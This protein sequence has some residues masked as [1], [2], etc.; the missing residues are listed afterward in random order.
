MILNR[1]RT[2]FTILWCVVC[3]FCACGIGAAG[4]TGPRLAVSEEVW[5]FGTIQEGDTVTHVFKLE[6]TGTSELVIRN[7]RT[8]CGCT[9]AMLSS[10][11]IAPGASGDL[12][13][14]FNSK[15]RPGYNEKS[16]YIDTNDPQRQHIRLQIDGHVKSPIE[17]DKPGIE[18]EPSAWSLGVVRAGTP[19]TR[20]FVVRNTGGLPLTIHAIE[21]P[22]GCT[23]TLFP[24]RSVPPGGA[25]RLE[26]TYIPKKRGAFQEAIFIESNDSD[27]PRVELAITGSLD[28]ADQPEI[29]IVP[30]EVSFG[31]L[32]QSKGAAETVSVQN[33][34][35]VDLMIGKISCSE[36]FSVEPS[37]LAS[38]PPGGESAFRVSIKE[39]MPAGPMHG[40]LFIDSNDPIEPKKEVPISGHIL[41]Q[42]V[43]QKANSRSGAVRIMVFH[44]EECKDCEYIKD[45]LLPQ[46]EK[47]HHVSLEVKYF[48][49]SAMENYEMLVRLEQQYRRE[50]NDLP[51]IFIGDFVLGGMDEIRKELGSIVEQYI[52]RGGSDWP[53]PE[54]PLQASPDGDRQGKV[55][56]AMFDKAGCRDCARVEH[57]LAN[58]KRKYPGLVTKKLLSSWPEDVL[59][60][61]A[62][63]EMIGVPKDRRLI[64]PTILVGNDY[65]ITD[66]ITDY[67]LDALVRKYLDTDQAPPWQGATMGATKAKDRIIE[68]FKSFGISAVL[69]AGLI[70]GI[71]PC[72]FATIIFFITYLTATG[73]KGRDIL[74]A[75]GAFTLSVFLTYFF[76]GLGAFKFIQSLAGFSVV[77]RVFYFLIA[78]L[79][80]TF[81]LLS[82][83]DYYK[84]RQGR[85]RDMKLQL[86]TLLKDRIHRAIQKNVKMRSVVLGAFVTGCLISLL[87]L[88]CTGQMYLPTIA[89]VASVPELRRN[90]VSSLV[91]Y[92]LMFVLPLILVLVAS[93]YGASSQR[94]GR[95][96]QRHLGQVKIVTG[97]FFLGLG[98]L[99]ILTA[100]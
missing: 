33:S 90:A 26:V 69:G 63:C 79:A 72:A 51:T 91:I 73:R 12:E 19:V 52:A 89:F 81:G 70:D 60:H 96:L 10:T 83:Y 17:P 76:V 35:D 54:K 50:G 5:D 92:N 99:L 46:L 9:A 42:G 15:G 23:A 39:E 97:L 28:L 20:M 14:T 40:S 57:M 98:V 43:P 4:V 61:E 37:S 41:A 25:A 80:L 85:V 56:L 30:P 87:E 16:V 18:I 29:S 31:T 27:K 24:D 62:M 59:I 86:P 74:M 78:V 93:F 8:T 32:G 45:H 77:S 7:V 34:G 67:K 94:F 71:N 58:L 66:E 100:V 2:I 48:E 47:E 55:Y 82:L 88:A 49:I 38:I 11:N 3:L 95:L 53:T 36:G 22:D 6:N 84:I 68:R 75:G 13:V 1:M 65:L 21:T 64:A 44:V